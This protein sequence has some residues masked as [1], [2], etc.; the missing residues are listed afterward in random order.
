MGRIGEIAAKDAGDAVDDAIASIARGRRIPLANA[1]ELFRLLGVRLPL[2]WFGLPLTDVAQALDP[3]L[4]R[5]R[6]RRRAWHERAPRVLRPPDHERRQRHRP[7]R[8]LRRGQVGTVRDLPPLRLPDTSLIFRARRFNALC[9]SGLFAGVVALAMWLT[10]TGHAAIFAFAVL[11]GLGSGA[12]RT[13][14]F[15]CC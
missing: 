13:G 3:L 12:F 2:A 8:W 15:M 9:V 1:R 6:L 14:A 7:P 10:V 4:L 11:Y 5:R